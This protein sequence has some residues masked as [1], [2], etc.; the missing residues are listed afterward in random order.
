MNPVSVD[1]AHQNYWYYTAAIIKSIA[2]KS[3][4]QYAGYT[5]RGKNYF[6]FCF[7]KCM[8]YK[9]MIWIDLEDIYMLFD[10]FVIH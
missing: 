7:V 5:A 4:Q 1:A 9:K 3:K 10:R 6:P 2:G 8:P